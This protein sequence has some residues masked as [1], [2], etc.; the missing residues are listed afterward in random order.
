MI[1]VV[2]DRFEVHVDE[3]GSRSF[4]SNLEC[5]RHVIVSLLNVVL[6]EC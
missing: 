2:E 6:L 4:E 5:W 1:D 3:G